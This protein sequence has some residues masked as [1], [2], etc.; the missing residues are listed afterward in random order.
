MRALW[1]AASSASG[2]WYLHT[3]WGPLLSAAIFAAVVAV[4]RPWS[5]H[6]H[7]SMARPQAAARK[8]ME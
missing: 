3:G 1:F 7:D 2:A 8:K 4:V 6:C 5:G